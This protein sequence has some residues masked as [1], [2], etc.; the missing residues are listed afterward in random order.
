MLSGVE[1]PRYLSYYQINF[2]DPEEEA[3]LEE[4]AKEEVG[5]KRDPARRSGGM[6]KLWHVH[7]AAYYAGH[8]V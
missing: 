4:A 8:V 3:R 2:R 7:C 1:S 5:Q 6:G